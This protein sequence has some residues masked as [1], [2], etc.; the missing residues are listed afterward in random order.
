MDDEVDYT[1]NNFYKADIDDYRGGTLTYQF[2]ELEEGQ[3]YVTLRVWDTH[4]NMAEEYLEF[5]VG[6]S[7]ELVIKNLL[8][9][10]NPFRDETT[11]SFEHNRSGQ[12]LEII[13]QIY[14]RNGSLVR[15]IEGET[16]NSEFRVNDIKW[17][18]RGGSG[19]KLES[20]IYI[21]RVYVRSL[22]DGAKNEDFEKLVIIN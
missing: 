18:G 16:V 11:F 19:K 10:P 2:T 4:N 1:L 21:Y 5:I 12:D 8:N 13:I 3:H 15:V 20:G 6:E 14:S 17:D 7:H 9:Y 22:V